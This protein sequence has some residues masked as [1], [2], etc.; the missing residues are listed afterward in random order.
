MANSYQGL[1]TTERFNNHN[2]AFTGNVWGGWTKGFARN[3]NIHALQASIQQIFPPVPNADELAAAVSDR[4]HADVK[5][6]E[7]M[8]VDGVCGPGPQLHYGMLITEISMAS[9]APRFNDETVEDLQWL[10]KQKGSVWN[11]LHFF[12]PLFQ[13]LFAPTKFLSK[14]YTTTRDAAPGNVDQVFGNKDRLSNQGHLMLLRK[15]R[16]REL[17]VADWLDESFESV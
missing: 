11:T 9:C 12:E 7:P 4:Q 8:L 13:A 15:L 10:Q 16:Q 2:Y 1:S 14:I 6:F 3:G 5:Y 17:G